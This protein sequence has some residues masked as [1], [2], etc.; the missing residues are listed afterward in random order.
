MREPVRR[1]KHIVQVKADCFK[2]WKT[3]ARGLHIS[4]AGNNFIS[5]FKQMGTNMPPEESCRAKE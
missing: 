5:L 2:A 3:P 4:H 1:G